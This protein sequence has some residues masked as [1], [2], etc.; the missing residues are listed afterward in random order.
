MKW[1]ERALTGFWFKRL[2]FPLLNLYIIQILLTRLL[3]QHNVE[4]FSQIH[5]DRIW[6]LHNMYIYFVLRLYMDVI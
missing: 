1:N 3:M 6:I 2:T 4:F 5:I